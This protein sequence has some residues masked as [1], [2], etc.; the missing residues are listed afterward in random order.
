MSR[1]PVPKTPEP[2]S[3]SGG[4]REQVSREGQGAKLGL[5][6]SEGWQGGLGL[7][8]NH[9]RGPSRGA[10]GTC[11]LPVTLGR[12]HRGARRGV[13]PGDVLVPFGVES[14]VLR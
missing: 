6:A 10:A 1:K 2:G 11:A 3:G 12:P 13:G 7:E 8:K 9:G 4:I 5:G 14:G